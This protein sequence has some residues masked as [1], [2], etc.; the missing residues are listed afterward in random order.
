MSELIITDDNYLSFVEP[1]EGMSKGLIPRDWETMQYGSQ[2][3]AAPFDIPLIPREQW[4]DLIA[5]RVRQKALLSKIIDDANIPSFD[6]N[7]TNYCHA[8]SPALALMAIRAVNGLPTVL[9]SPGYLGSMITGGRNVG[10]WIID[11]LKGIVKYGIASQE[12]VAQNYV[13]RNFKEGAHEDAAK[14]KCEEWWDFPRDRRA[15]DR[16]M[17]CLL[18]GIPVCTGHNWWSHAVTAIDPV[19]ENGKFGAR[20]RNSWGARYGTNGYF[21]MFEGK[22]TPDEAYAPRVATV[23]VRNVANSSVH[24]VA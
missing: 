3:F 5:D 23:S 7:G 21:I 1:P 16:M 4:P 20:F 12:F 24:V 13:G 10:A 9:L 2:E 17:T 8:H 14:Y 11:D 18:L 22:G 19:Y 15:F 6:Q